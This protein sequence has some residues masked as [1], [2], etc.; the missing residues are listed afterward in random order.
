MGEIVRPVSGSDKG[1]IRRAKSRVGLSPLSLN[2][3]PRLTPFRELAANAVSDKDED[4][5]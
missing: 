3:N 5:D 1:K 4:E 2:L